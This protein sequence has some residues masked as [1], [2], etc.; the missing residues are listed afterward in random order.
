MSDTLENKV[1]PKNSQSPQLT[2]NNDDILWRIIWAKKFTIIS[3]SFLFAVG[4]IFF[5]L[6]KPNIYRASSILAPAS[7]EGGPGGLAGIASQFGG[8]ASMAGLNLSGGGTDKTTLALEIIRSRS[9]IEKFITKH[10]LL[11][12]LIAAENWDMASDTLILDKELYDQENK[13]WVRQVKAPKKVIP[14]YWEAYQQFSELLTVSQSE[15]T[16]MVSIA[17]EFYSPKLAKQW[18]SWLIADIN[19]FMRTQDKKEAQASI[20][21]LNKQLE[22][23]QVSNMESVFYQLIEEQTKSMMLAHVKVE[24]VLKTIDPAQVP[25]KKAKPKR[26]LIVI[27]GTLFGGVLSILLVLVRF[28]LK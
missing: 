9:F 2:S 26:A 23:I 5:A 27:I 3:I 19:E 7:S 8:L 21:Y 28:Y 6:S 15:K 14:S 11:I 10:N 24:Y 22:T 1:I 4:S 16:S 12:P 17:I 20:D 18:L 25:E 13:K